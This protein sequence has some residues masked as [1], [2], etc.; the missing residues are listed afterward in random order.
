MAGFSL[1][2]NK[3]EIKPRVVESTE[4]IKESR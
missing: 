2:D 1:K 4:E 3:D